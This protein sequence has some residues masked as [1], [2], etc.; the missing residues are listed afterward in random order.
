MSAIP[1]VIARVEQGTAT[2]RDWYE[3]LEHLQRERDLFERLAENL[4]AYD[5]RIIIRVDSNEKLFRFSSI[6]AL[7]EW[8]AEGWK[9]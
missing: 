3:V 8:L 9:K 2:I 5:E 6:D 1:K 4:P 7:A